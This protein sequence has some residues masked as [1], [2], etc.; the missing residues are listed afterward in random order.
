MNKRKRED[1]NLLKQNRPKVLERDNYSCV[2]CG[3]HDGIA[4][5][6]IVFRSQLGK[7]TMDNLACLCIHCHIPIA[8]G[9]DAKLV[10]KRLQEIVKERT[11]RYERTQSY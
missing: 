2:L 9:C 7:S 11:Y 3:G 5:H 1:E 8:H 4:I 6:H 10:R